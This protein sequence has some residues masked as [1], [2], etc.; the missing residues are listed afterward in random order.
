MSI[1]RTT[2]RITQTT[3]GGAEAFQAILQALQEVV[4][5]CLI[6]CLQLN[7][8]KFQINTA[9]YPQNIW[10]Q[11]LSHEA[12]HPKLVFHLINS[13]AEEDPEKRQ[14]LKGLFHQL[15]A[16]PTTKVTAF[17]TF[18]FESDSTPEML[19]SHGLPKV[20][21][22]GCELTVDAYTE[23]LKEANRRNLAGTS[24]GQEGARLQRQLY[25]S[26]MPVAGKVFGGLSPALSVR[27]VLEQA[28]ARKGVS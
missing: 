8:T 3:R 25:Q 21:S 19:H 22:Y 4:P 17:G 23:H 26:L 28:G 13:L 2:F 18:L 20:S 9:R 10:H 11:L 16:D 5:F 15:L 24:V 14:Q 1:R 6:D 27:K 7:R 12:W